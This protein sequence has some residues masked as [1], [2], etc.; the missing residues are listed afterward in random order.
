MN[1]K[2]RNFFKALKDIK[3]ISVDIFSS[4]FYS[5]TKIEGVCCGH[6]IK[7]IREKIKTSEDIN[8]FKRIQNEIIETVIYRILET[9]DGYGSLEFKVDIV[10]KKT[11]ESLRDGIELHDEFI[12]Y[13]R[14][15]E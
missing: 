11:G 12:N 14:E 1:D 7:N 13:L 10:E 6:D 4:Y 8:S 2:Q 3:D 15:S 5:D 9:F